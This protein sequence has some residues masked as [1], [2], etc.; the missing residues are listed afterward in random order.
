[1]SFSQRPNKNS[2]LWRYA[3]L[4]VQ[5]FAALG[6]AVFAG[7][8]ADGWLNFS[9]PLLVWIF[10]LLFIAGMIYKLIKDTNRK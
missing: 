1:M 2:D 7:I 8:K 6:L 10:P 4:G 3:G 5:I 9:S